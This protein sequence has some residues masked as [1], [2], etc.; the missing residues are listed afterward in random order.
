[1]KQNKS[2]HNHLRKGI[3]KGKLKVS[4]VFPNVMKTGIETIDKLFLQEQKS[5]LVQHGSDEEIPD[6][7]VLFTENN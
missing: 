4:T 5:S 3:N 2:L 7:D 1:M 6:F